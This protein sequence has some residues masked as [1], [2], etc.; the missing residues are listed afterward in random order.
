MMQHTYSLTIS[1]GSREQQLSLFPAIE[2]GTWSPYH[3]AATHTRGV[4]GSK[5]QRPLWGTGAPAGLLPA[6][7]IP[8]RNGRTRAWGPCPA[9]MDCLHPCCFHA[10]Q[11]YAGKGMRA[12]VL[13][14][15]WLWSSS[16]LW[17]K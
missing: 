13:L 6:P 11:G 7:S 15:K 12:C 2:K 4:S 1:S 5:W 9:L 16:I 17:Q 10:S 14:Q 3:S 8:R